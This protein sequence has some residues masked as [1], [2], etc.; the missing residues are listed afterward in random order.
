MKKFVSFFAVF[1][2]ITLFAVASEAGDRNIP[3]EVAQLTDSLKKQ[4][5][6]DR[7][8]ALLDV[9]YSFSDK[10][11]M[12]RGVTTSAEAKNALLKELARKGYTVMDC[13]ELLPDVKGLEGKTCGIINVSVANMR[14]APDFSSEMMTQ[15]LMGMPVRVLQR[16]GWVRIQTPDNYIAWVHRVGVHPVTEEEMAAWNKA[17]K[18]V[19]TAHYG[20]VYSEPNQTSQTVS[21]VVAGNRL[22]W[23]GS[24]GA[25]YKV[26][27]PDGRRGYISKSIAMPEK[28]WRSGLQQDA[29]GI[30][31]TAHTMMGIPVFRQTFID[32]F[33]DA[34]FYLLNQT[35]APAASSLMNSRDC[36]RE[37]TVGGVRRSASSDPAARMLVTCFFLQTLTA[38]SSFLGDM[39]TIMPS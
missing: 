10:N 1:L 2:F 8:V 39:P 15:S 19:V 28:K 14:V 27:Y 5:A 18:I 22:K 29:A 13:L 33:F 21:D 16:D 32:Q 34:C 17:E 12:L 30:I 9:D 36:S 20:F 23:E 7:R 26:T 25:F 3:V 11:V 24:K 38:I 6:P 4:F 31:R 37:K 35:A